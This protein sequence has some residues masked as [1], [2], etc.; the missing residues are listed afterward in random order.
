[1]S[2]L[3]TDDI[4]ELAEL[5]KLL[6]ANVHAQVKMLKHVIIGLKRKL[7]VE[8]EAHMA[9]RRELCNYFADSDTDNS[10]I[11]AQG[12]SDRRALAEIGSAEEKLISVK[13]ELASLTSNMVTCTEI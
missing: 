5:E 6:P 11:S 4:Q 9:V 13:A 7:K 2:D 8:N 3:S 1:M 12:K 10:S